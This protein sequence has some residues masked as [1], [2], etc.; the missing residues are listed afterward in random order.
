MI[1]K[2]DVGCVLPTHFLGRSTDYSIGFAQA[3]EKHKGLEARL[4]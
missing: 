4:K 1:G 3:D 2:E